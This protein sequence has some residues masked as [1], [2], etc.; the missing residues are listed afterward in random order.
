MPPPDW[1][2]ES[3]PDWLILVAIDNLAHW[4]FLELSVLSGHCMGLDGRWW[5]VRVWP[6]FWF[7]SVR[8][9]VGVVL[10]ARC[11]PFGAYSPGVQLS[12][13][14]EPS[15]VASVHPGGGEDRKPAH[16]EVGQPGYITE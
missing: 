11:F 13:R 16:Q 5:G 10:G 15:G 7:S 12:Q 4:C 14:G 8:Q 3:S 2:E 6:A 9:V 1:S